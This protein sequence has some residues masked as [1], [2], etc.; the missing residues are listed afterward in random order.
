MKITIRFYGI[1]Y[2][3][4]NLRESIQEIPEKS[5]IK[6]LFKI[7]VAQFPGLS[8]LIYDN[9]Q[10]KLDYLAISVNNQDILGLNSF[11]TILHDGDKVFIMPPIGGG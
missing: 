9:N 8:E 10:I 2:D 4:T 6:D 3:K 1:A 5:T 7:I 11:N